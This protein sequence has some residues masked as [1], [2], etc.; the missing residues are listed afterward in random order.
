[1]TKDVILSIKGMQYDIS[2][3]EATEVITPGSYYFKNG[4]DYILYDEI[5]PETG[6]KISNTLK[7][8]DGRIDL[9]K[10]G[11]DSVH[12]IFEEKKKN[13][14]LYRTPYGVME[15][16]LN[17]FNLNICHSEKLI[18]AKIHYGLEI[19]AGFVSDCGIDLNIRPKEVTIETE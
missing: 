6:E 1:M 5:V 13:I 15:V 16:G 18:E 17:T 12:M 8:S 11:T 10:R 4:K 2:P 14:A 9:L 3:D 7:I 19:N